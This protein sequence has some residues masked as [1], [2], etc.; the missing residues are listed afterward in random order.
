MRPEAA[1][2]AAIP[3][4][5]P[6]K[7][8]QEWLEQAAF[9]DRVKNDFFDKAYAEILLDI[10]QQWLRTGPEEQE[11]REYLYHVALGLGDVKNRLIGYV[12]V[13]SN[14]EFMNNTTKEP[15]TS[16]SI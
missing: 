16:D 11:V 10:F 15:N 9:A 3:V 13:G 1:A 12:E 14:I 5:D 2:E 8:S 7:T 6:Y 4:V